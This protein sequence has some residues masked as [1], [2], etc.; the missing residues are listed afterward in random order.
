M[1]TRTAQR[2]ILSITVIVGILI[3][4]SVVYEAWVTIGVR[5]VR[6]DKEVLADKLSG[7]D[8][9]RVAEACRSLMKRA[10]IQNDPLS[11]VPILLVPGAETTGDI[12]S[13][14]SALGP[15]WIE[16]R[17][18]IVTVQMA[19]DRRIY[20][21]AFPEGVRGNGTQRL[22]SGLWY[23]NG[24]TGEQRSRG[25]SSFSTDDRLTTRENDSGD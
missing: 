25:A 4:V 21:L 8:L 16:V 20:L 1:K 10:S 6:N 19:P 17:P 12:P 13:E 9:D 23:W 14:L 22:A 3:A 18:Y 24:R 7:H 5:I 2:V 11:D 15:T